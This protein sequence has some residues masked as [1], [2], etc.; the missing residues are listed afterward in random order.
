MKSQV[1]EEKKKHVSESDVVKNH[2]SHER[3]K[4]VAASY[5]RLCVVRCR[6]CTSLKVEW[7]NEWAKGRTKQEREE[8]KRWNSLFIKNPFTI[9]ASPQSAHK[10]TSPRINLLLFLL[11]FFLS[12]FYCAHPFLLAVSKLA[13][14]SVQCFMFVCSLS[15]VPRVCVCVF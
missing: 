10:S 11:S 12:I 7:I 1:E 2:K 5:R 8:N 15:V 13:E 14:I 4:T 9:F 6:H 3:V